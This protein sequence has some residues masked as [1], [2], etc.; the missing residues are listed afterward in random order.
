MEIDQLI[1]QITQAPIATA[2][3]PYSERCVGIVEHI[4]RLCADDVCA[5]RGSILQL[6]A[7]VRLIAGHLADD[8]D[9][10]ALAPADAAQVLRHL[11][12]IGRLAFCL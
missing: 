7:R 10:G 6:I 2:N 12:D 3:Y 8:L 9:S 11:E 1:S 5:R 4:A